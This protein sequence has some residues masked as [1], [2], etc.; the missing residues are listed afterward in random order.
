VPAAAGGSGLAGAAGEVH[1]SRR[2]ALAAHGP[3]RGD[4]PRGIGL[5]LRVARGRLG[6]VW[7]GLAG[8]AVPEAQGRPSRVGQGP[9]GPA[10][11]GGSAGWGGGGGGGRGGRMGRC[12][13]RVRWWAGA[14]AGAT[15]IPRAPGAVCPRASPASWSG[16]TWIRSP[17]T[18]MPSRIPTSGSPAEIAG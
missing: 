2:G 3:R 11:G 13:G 7:L 18:M 8:G 4:G 16:A 15:R 17:K 5:V 6:P 9:G 14:G 12:G 1:V 10:A